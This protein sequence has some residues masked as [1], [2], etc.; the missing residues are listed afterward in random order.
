MSSSSPTELGFTSVIM[1][2]AGDRQWRYGIQ[3][4]GRIVITVVGFTVIVVGIG[5]PIIPGDGHPSIM[6]GG[7]SMVLM[8]GCGLLVRSGALHG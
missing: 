2:G 3:G 5:I 4:G 7:L 1:V 8:G 6:A